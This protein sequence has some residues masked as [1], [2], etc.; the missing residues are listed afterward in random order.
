MMELLTTGLIPIL[1]LAGAAMLALLAWVNRDSS[2][3]VDE[4]SDPDHHTLR[5]DYQSGM[6]GGSVR[7]WKVPKDQAAYARMFVPKTHAHSDASDKS[8]K[9]DTT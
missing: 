2:P 9:S 3:M 4:D 8:A 5:S 1:I 6:G 7:T